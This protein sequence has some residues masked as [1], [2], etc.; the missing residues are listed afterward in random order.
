MEL[1]WMILGNI[2]GLS[3]M[4]GGISLCVRH[5][6]A[7]KTRR[8][9]LEHTERM[10]AIELGLP[11]EDAD[12]AR[13]QALGA[14]GVAVPIVSMISAA[15]ASCFVLAIKD[16]LWQFGSMAV[17]WLT[18]GTVCLFAVPAI[19]SGLLNDRTDRKPTNMTL[20]STR[21]LPGTE[22]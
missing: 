13:Y 11:L 3:V 20:Q 12:V 1:L 4:F 10:R 19:I 5:D 14:I 6:Q 15:L 21:P 16:P 22:E 8:R 18:V 7:G 17:I 2:V 9:E